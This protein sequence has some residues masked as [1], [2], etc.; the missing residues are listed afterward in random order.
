ME[1]AVQQVITTEYGLHI[2]SVEDLG[3]KSAKIVSNQGEF[4]AKYLATSDESEQLAN[5]HVAAYGVLNQHQIPALSLYP[6][7]N[8]Q[9]F[10]WAADKIVFLYRYLQGQHPIFDTRF[11]RELGLLL[12]TLHSLPAKS[13]K[14]PSEYHPRYHIMQLEQRLQRIRGPHNNAEVSTLRE[15]LEQGTPWEL[16]PQTFIHGDPYYFNL[17]RDSRD[18]LHFIDLDLAGLA[19]A[20][21]DV[22]FVIAQ[23]C[24][25]SPKLSKAIYW[26][27]PGAGEVW[28]TRRSERSTQAFLQSYQSVRPLSQLELL[29]LVDAVWLATIRHIDSPDQKQI[30]PEYFARSQQTAEFLKRVLPSSEQVFMQPAI[31]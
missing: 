19:P 15:I 30:N 27:V 13:Y 28:E 22:G 26:Q 21:V 8:G 7:R 14:Y 1:S 20:I 12:A 2:T 5:R 10:V 24:F 3:G 4:V 11:F 29:H 6:A 16:L 31:A 17:V 23:M 18:I 9:Q 25:M